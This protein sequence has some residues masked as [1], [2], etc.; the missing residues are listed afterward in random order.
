MAHSA[1]GLSKQA[2]GSSVILQ[3][4]DAVFFLKGL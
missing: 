3:Y 4:S 1:E 2:H